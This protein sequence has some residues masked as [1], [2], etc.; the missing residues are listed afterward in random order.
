VKVKGTRKQTLVTQF[1]E[2][3]NRE[4]CW[5]NVRLK[6]LVTIHYGASLPDNVRQSGEI[7]VY[8]SNGIVGSH[9]SSYVKGPGIIIGRKGSGGAINFCNS[10]FWPID[11][12]YYLE[13]SERYNLK[14]L[15]YALDTLQLT[16]LNSLT[17]VPGL[18]REDVYQQYLLLPP[19]PEQQRIATVL[20]TVD[21]A[22]AATDAIITKIEV[23]RQELRDILFTQA[24]NPQTN[25]D[26]PPDKKP[27]QWE[28]RSIESLCSLIADCPHS[29][30]K[31]IGEGFLVIRNY[32]I[33]DGRLDLLFPS[34]TSEEEFKERNNRAI[35]TEGDVLFS[36]EAPMGEACMLPAGV[37]CCLGQR[38]M[39]LR[40]DPDSID[41]MFLVHSIYSPPIRQIM[42]ATAMGQTVLRL[43][44]A[45]VKRLPI[46]LPP[47]PEQRRIAAILATVDD[48]LATERAERDRLVALKKGLMQ[49]LLTGRVRVPSGVTGEV[50]PAH[51]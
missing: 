19:L 36:R 15:Y 44:I 40:P 22:I 48:R 43:N 1:F 37:R 9:C 34:F 18:N 46:P 14:W 49:V 39:L 24:I 23:I 35:P 45:D 41:S 42:K 51:V 5:Q 2:E 3:D 10:D 16:K 26:T 31:Y 11:T 28:L 20:A 29:T 12:T 8:G 27:K 38:M 50:A 6:E 13:S 30:P 33:R 4:Y 47:L 32:N 17:G 25:K 21:E 7:P